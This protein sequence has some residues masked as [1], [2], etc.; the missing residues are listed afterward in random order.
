MNCHLWIKDEQSATL[1]QP[2]FRFL[3]PVLIH[4]AEM[5]KLGWIITMQ[6]RSYTSYT[7]C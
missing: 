5:P 4:T 7:S 1:Y 2:S 6:T 3:S